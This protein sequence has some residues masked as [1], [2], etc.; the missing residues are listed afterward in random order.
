[1]RKLEDFLAMPDVSEMKEEVYINERLGAF[2][3]APMDDD[4]VKRYRNKCKIGKNGI[5]IDNE[6]FQIALITGQVIEP[7][8]SDA[9]FLANAKCTT[10]SEFIKR[11]FKAGEI[12]DIASKITKA[13]G[14]NKEGKDINDYIEEAKD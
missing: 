12:A 2:I 3:I 11:K 4:Q 6:K 5:E 14:F 9:E 8:F 7:N 1:M 10:A 13:S